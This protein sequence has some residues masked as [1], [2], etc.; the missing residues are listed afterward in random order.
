MTESRLEAPVAERSGVAGTRG[1]ENPPKTAAF[2]RVASIF[3]QPWWLDAVAPGRWRAVETRDGNGPRARIVVAGTRRAGFSAATPPPYTP[4]QGPWLREVEGGAAHRL[5]A[6]TEALDELV[7]ALPSLDLIRLGLSPELPT[8]LPFVW[9]GFTA[10]PRVTYRLDDLRDLDAVWAGFR[11]NLRRQVRSAERRLGVRDGDAEALIAAA[12]ATFARQGLALPH[13]DPLRRLDAALAARGAR[14]ILLA[15]DAGGRLH[16]ALLVVWDS[17]RA[18][19]LIGGQTD[20]GRG[21]GG[22]SLL[23]WHAI[24]HAAQVSRGFDFEGSMI[25]SIERFFRSF[26]ARQV[27]YVEV[28]K[29]GRRLAPVLALRDAVRGLRRP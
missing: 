7:A 26:G 20:I 5:N 28:T 23:M 21:E 24:R 11:Q 17:H 18:Y 22:A 13:A 3:E 27:P 9:R 4:L 16:A 15:E 12:A 6:Q 2:D 1:G 29:A 25:P 19:Y 10:Q 8:F 14:R